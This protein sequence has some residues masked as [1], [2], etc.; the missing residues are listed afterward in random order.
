MIMTIVE[1]AIPMPEKSMMIMGKTRF[2]RRSD[3]SKIYL[4]GLSPSSITIETALP[5]K[6]FFIPAKSVNVSIGPDEPPPPNNLISIKVDMV[7]N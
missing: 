7:G 6:E 2:Y 1:S 4:I 5:R 3:M